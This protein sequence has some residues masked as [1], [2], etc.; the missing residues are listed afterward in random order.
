MVF[1]LFEAR[2][3]GVWPSLSLASIMHLR[4]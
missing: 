2:K 1:P 3:S 4:F